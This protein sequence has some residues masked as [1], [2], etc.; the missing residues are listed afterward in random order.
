MIT[1]VDDCALTSLPRIA[2]SRG[3]LCFVEGQKHVPFDVARLF[4]MY[5]FPAGTRRGGHAHKECHQFLIAQEG[6]FEISMDDGK[7]KRSIRLDRPDQGL[8]VPPGIWLELLS[9]GE[10]SVITALASHRYAELDYL[11]AYEGFVSWKNSLLEDR[12][13]SH[14]RIRVRPY[15]MGDAAALSA[16]VVASAAVVGRWLSWC[17]PGYDQK[18]AAAYIQLVNHLAGM[19]KEYSYGIFSSGPDRRHLGGVTLNRID[20]TALSAN[21]GYWRVT[22]PVGKGIA[23]TAARLVCSYAFRKLG[24]N[25]IEIVV[26]VGNDSS[27]RVAEKLG[28]KL[29]GTLRGKIPRD[30]AFFDA[31][32]YSVLPGDLINPTHD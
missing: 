22:D 9:L 12:E 29:E 5:D 13:L 21:L 20:W 3:A 24:L 26:E 18:T 31:C 14:E 6:E 15:N 16:S 2:D 23:T 4:Y 27:M 11:R 32:I 10:P 19:R 8:H 7:T 17:K 28:G 25:R 1:T 30:G